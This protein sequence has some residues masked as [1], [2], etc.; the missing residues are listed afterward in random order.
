MYVREC[1]VDTFFKASTPALVLPSAASCTPSAPG[2]LFCGSL[3]VLPPACA[4]AR[5]PSSQLPAMVHCV[6]PGYQKRLLGVA[7][8]SGPRELPEVTQHAH[9]PP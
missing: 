6:L 9:L 4:C 1:M 2:V 8:L 5:P 7:T 3:H